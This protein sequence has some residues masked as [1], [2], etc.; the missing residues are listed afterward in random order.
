MRE[1]SI[2]QPTI[3]ARIAAPMD[4]TVVGED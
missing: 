1:E 2:L 4:R 3:T